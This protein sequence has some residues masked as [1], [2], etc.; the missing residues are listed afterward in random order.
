MPFKRNSKK[1]KNRS[2]RR[3]ET[4]PK[5][6]RFTKEDLFEIDYRD[7]DTLR[8]FTSAQG[9]INPNKRN[10][11]SSYYQRQLRVAIKRA[12]FLALLPYVGD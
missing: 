6:C 2:K 8:R 1:N 5:A 12:R 3:Q 9:K 4:T 10:G 11:I 7:I